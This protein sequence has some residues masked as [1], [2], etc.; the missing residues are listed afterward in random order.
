MRTTLAAVGALAAKDLRLLSR[1]R[2][3]LFFAV[4]WPLLMALAFGF[5]FGGGGGERGKI[6]IAGVDE[7]GTPAAEELLAEL[8]RQ[9]GLDVVRATRAEAEQLVRAGKRTAAVVVPKG[10]GA[11]ADRPFAATRRLELA[12]DPAR[13]AEL[14]M[15]EGILTGAAM[16]SM[17]DLFTDPARSRAMA[18][19]ALADLEDAPAGDDTDATR[20][21]LGELKAFNDRPRPAGAGGGSGAA[22]PLEIARLELGPARRRPSNPFEITF[23]QGMLWGVIGCALGFAVSLVTERTRGTLPRLL[24]SPLSRGHVLAGKALACFAAI[25]TVELGLLLVGAAFFGLA[26]PSW[27]L[28]AIAACSVAICFVGI[29]MLVAV[30]GK[31][32]QA[33][34]G[35]GWAVM[36]PFAML[37][38]GMV[39]LFFMPSWM[40]TVGSVSPVKW[41]IL[42]LEG[43]IWRGFG[44]AEL[45]LPCGILLAVGAAGLAAGALLFRAEA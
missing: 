35:M 3:A 5:L 40:Q 37:G 27:G 16:K 4:A 17:Q 29:M 7:D 2:P 24:T 8:G 21:F 22:K 1:N 10:Y 9:E 43:A 41:G 33:A 38:G 15:L 36:M 42:A 25:L 31:T 13:K 34:G 26:P 19:R 12:G 6:R 11:A 32:E 18:E 28:V 20:R 14:G 44:P 45:A 23:P 39:P 30:V